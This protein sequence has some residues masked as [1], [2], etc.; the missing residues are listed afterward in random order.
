MRSIR[1]IGAIFIYLSL[2]V[3]Q[4]CGGFETFEVILYAI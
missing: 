2:Q 1:I 4:H 3:E